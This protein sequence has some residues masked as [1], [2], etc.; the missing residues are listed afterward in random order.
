M[1]ERAADAFQGVRQ[2]SPRPGKQLPGV[3]IDGRSVVNI[4]YSNEREEKASILKP[5]RYPLTVPPYFPLKVE[6][7]YIS[8]APFDFT[9]FKSWIK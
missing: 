8:S 2:A 9:E 6:A 3:M 1:E 5:F 4:L 7:E